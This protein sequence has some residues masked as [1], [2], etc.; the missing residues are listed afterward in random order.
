M[1]NVAYIGLSRQ[2]TLRR[3]LDIEANNIANANTTGFKVEQ[4]MVG[5]EVGQGARNDAVR[6][7]VSFVLDRGV[8]RDYGQ[9]ALSQ[10]ARTLDFAIE[11]EGAFFTVQ[12]GDGEAY[13]RDGAFTISPAGLLV[14]A[15]GLP[16]LGAGGEILLAPARGAPQVAGDGTIS[17]DGLTAFEQLEKVTAE[18]AMLMIDQQ[19]RWREL[20]RE[21]AAEGLRLVEADAGTAAARASASSTAS[22]ARSR[23]SSPAPGARLSTVRLRRQVRAPGRPCIRPS[24]CRAMAGSATPSSSRAAI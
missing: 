24:M 18:A 17:Q 11:G 10:T 19:N 12:D 7:G 22:S 14:P 21:L 20:R 16:V 13:T 15:S 5:T 1:E 2:M 3:E 4:L 9:G 23:P 8:G 6:P